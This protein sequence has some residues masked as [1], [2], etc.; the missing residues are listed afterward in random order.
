VTQA[1]NNFTI[2]PACGEI[3]SLRQAARQYINEFTVSLLL[4]AKAIA[5]RQKAAIVLSNHV[6]EAHDIVSSPTK[7]RSSELKLAFGGALLGAFLQGFANELSLTTLR[8]FWI[9]VYVV[10]GFAGA[11]LVFWGIRQ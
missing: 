6:E 10:A 8:P 9:A 1:G 11:L 5:H 2:N 3:V 4:E 7:S